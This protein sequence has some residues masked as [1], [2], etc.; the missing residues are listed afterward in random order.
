MS[1]SVT[2]QISRKIDHKHGHGL[3]HEKNNGLIHET[4]TFYFRI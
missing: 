3:N 1:I 2:K 4:D